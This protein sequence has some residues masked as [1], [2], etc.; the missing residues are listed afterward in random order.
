MDNREAFN[1][2]DQENPQVFRSLLAFAF[3]ARRAGINHL[4]MRLLFE[5]ARWDF[6]LRTDS[7]DGFKINNN[8]APYYARKIIEQY[9]EF[10]GFF[11]LRPCRGEQGTL[12][13]R[14]AA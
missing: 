14:Q 11:E 7:R 8:Y 1:Q 6:K 9:P 3:E 12:F 10:A 4:G 13:G 5:R 2:Y